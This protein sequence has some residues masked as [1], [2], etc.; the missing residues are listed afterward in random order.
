VIDVEVAD[1]DLILVGHT[2]GAAMLEVA[3]QV[4]SGL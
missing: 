3:S 1:V 4:V 2:V